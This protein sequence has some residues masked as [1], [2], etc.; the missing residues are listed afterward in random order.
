MFRV[1]LDVYFATG[2]AGA[3][4]LF[5]LTGFLPWFFVL[6]LV[7]VFAGGFWAGAGVV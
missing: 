5:F 7:V 2:V 3:A 6:F 1:D 4:A